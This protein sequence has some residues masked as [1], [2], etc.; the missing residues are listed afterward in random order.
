MGAVLLQN[1]KPICFHSETFSKTV[2]NYLTYDK[3]LFGLVESVNKWKQYI[4]GKKTLI[5]IDHQLLQSRN[6]LQ[7]SLH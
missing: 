6:K 3:E 5:H 1:G 7:Q 4:M 2:I